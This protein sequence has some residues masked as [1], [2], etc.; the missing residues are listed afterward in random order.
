MKDRVKIVECPRDAWQ[1]LPAIIPAEV[2]AGYLNTLTRGGFR[3]IDAVSFVSPAAV[4]Q[5]ADSELVLT[6][7]EIA[8]DVEIIGIVANVKGAERAI[9]SRR[10]KTLGFPFSISESF[11]ARNQRQTKEQA[12]EA[13]GTM[14]RMAQEQG[15]GLVVYVSM[16]FGNPYAEPWHAGLVL[17]ACDALVGKGVRT[18]SLADTVGIASAETIAEVV[19]AVIEHC[20]DVEVG[21]HLHARREQSAAKIRAAYGSGCRRFDAAIGGLGGCPFAQDA[22]VGNLRTE[23]LVGVLQELGAEIEEPLTLEQPARENARIAATYG[24]AQT[25]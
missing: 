16:A 10:V 19:G 18:I 21:A 1:G 4:P 13:A 23:V 6:L 2:K 11:L 14:A 5:M 7:L 8:E 3:H 9:E 17:E 12:L 22:L 24:H 20:G 15:M 25:S